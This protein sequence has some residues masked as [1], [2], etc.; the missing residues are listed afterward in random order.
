MPAGV[1][2]LNSLENFVLLIQISQKGDITYMRPRG[3][4]PI[5]LHIRKNYK[6]MRYRINSP[7]NDIYIFALSRPASPVQ[8]YMQ[9]N[10]CKSL[11]PRRALNP[12]SM[13]GHLKTAS[14]SYTN[15]AAKL[16][17]TFL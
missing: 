9:A 10:R 17:V 13:I 11:Y 3:L 7:F 4:P 12:L 16:K 6:Q 14:L 5:P 8:I 2:C 15:V 1:V